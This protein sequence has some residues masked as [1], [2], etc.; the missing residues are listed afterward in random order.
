VSE[1]APQ[2]I[3]FRPLA[4]ADFPVLTRWLA[5]P[6]VRRFYQKQ[7][8]TLAEVAAEYG[9]AVRGEEPSICH[10]ALRDGAPFA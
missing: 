3:S 7:P 10:L 4:V 8:I 2:G 6:H 1:I 5:E 9:T